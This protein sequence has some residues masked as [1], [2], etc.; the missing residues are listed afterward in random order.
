MS[1]CTECGAATTAGSSTCANC[2][3]QSSAVKSYCLV[4]L[5]GPHAGL[6]HPIPAGGLRIGRVPDLNDV[7]IADPEVSRQHAKIAVKNGGVQLTDTSAN[8]TFVNGQRI[9]EARLQTGDRIQFG[10]NST[11]TLVVQFDVL[12]AVAAASVSPAPMARSSHTVLASA[13]A[14]RA[15]DSTLIMSEHEEDAPRRRLQLI[16]DQYAVKDI[17]LE[18]PRLEF[19]RDEAPGRILVDH[20]SISS[21]HAEI[22]P[23]KAGAVLRD[24]QST[25]GTFVNS[26]RVQERLLQEGDLIQFGAC[27]SH[28]FLYRES[29]R[30]PLVLRDI[31]LDRPLVT[32]GRAAENNICIAHPTV[33][34]HHAQIRK[35]SEGYELTD[36]GS[37]NGTFVNGQ[38]ITRQILRPGSRV[39]L[40]AAQF[41]FDGQ[42]MEQQSDGSRLR[43]T[44]RSLRVEA[45]DFNTGVPIRLLDDVSLAIEPCE[46]VGLLGP[47]GAGKSTLMDA[48]NGSRPAQKGRVLLNSADLY[49][50][51]ASLRSSIGYV[52]QEDILHRQLTVKEC[53]YYAARLQ[54]PDDFREKDLWERVNE[55]IKVLELAERA[56]LAIAQLS[57]GQRKRV[58]L[59]IEL[60]SKP[61]LLFVDEPTAGQDPRTEMK[62]MQLFREI[63]NRG[64]TVV[65]NTH[66]L[67]SFSLLDKVA[68]L[69]RGK[70]A[71]FGRNHEML[72]YFNARRPQE[73]FDK[74]QE[75]KPEAWA[76][77]YQQSDPYREFCAGANGNDG[78]QRHSASG[79]QAQPPKRSS[80]RQ[81]VTLL[82]RQFTL[83]FKEKST[84]A[85]LL[86]PPVAIA[87][88]MALLKQG[89]NEPKVLFMV[90]VVALWFGC[91]G[92]V[93]EIVDELPVYKRERQRDLKLASYIGS[94]LVYVISVA[95][96]Q[97][98]LLIAVLTLMGA[99]K[100]HLPEA[101]LL[102]WLMTVEGALIGLV[103]SAVCSTAEKA[104]YAFPLTMIPQMLLAGLLIPVAAITPFYPV[105]LPAGRGTAI[106]ELPKVPAM[107][108]PLADGVSPFMVS[109]WGL[110]ALSD[111]YVHDREAGSILRKNYSYQLLAA[112]AITLHRDDSEDAR[113]ELTRTPARPGRPT[114]PAR[115]ASDPSA[116]R[117]ASDTLGEYTGIL[118]AFAL[119]FITAIAVALKRKESHARA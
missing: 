83:K 78:V 60:L 57:G 59:G 84:F 88:L 87:V 49:S 66:L 103:I 47:S 31:E 71:Y 8:G 56:D 101:F 85:A 81:L 62:M 6:R 36:L 113:A 68:V 116:S 38:R 70:L 111:L 118:G 15:L 12:V 105:Q 44:C 98:V 14:A 79:Q 112:V 17:P 75:K 40:G 33:S 28:L 91:S 2:E 34:S 18:G 30:R 43:I 102:T 92:S 72:P 64:S 20:T 51:F 19:G 11:N 55:T 108:K 41:A 80:W 22:A 4:G 104:L 107:I 74:L 90:V 53:L 96:M 63:A 61:A 32:I 76:A 16:L 95:A 13:A 77:Q 54:L 24:L 69:V 3:S 117:P 26:E 93:R 50:E 27:D 119:V 39:S 48:M 45:K 1:F 10:L 9:T 42:R 89:P 23:T 21:R 46:F 115:P 100:G 29:G 52:P 99:I 114:V 58:S 67:G 5:P 94:K 73:I 7:V 82:R 25:N 86:L 35:V 65:I 110:E 97:A 109:R 106:Q 37:T